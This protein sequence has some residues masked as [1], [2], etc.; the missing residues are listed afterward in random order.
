MKTKPRSLILTDSD[1][2]HSQNNHHSSTGGKPMRTTGGSLDLTHHQTHV[3][4]N[5]DNVDKILEKL[6]T[7]TAFVNDIE[8]N[9]APPETYPPPKAKV[10]LL[11]L[12]ESEAVYADVV[13]YDKDGNKFPAVTKAIPL[14]AIRRLFDV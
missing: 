10:A 6:C 3:Q 7:Y 13:K 12:L 8:W 9:M 2:T 14:E 1:S 4:T 5:S 11:D